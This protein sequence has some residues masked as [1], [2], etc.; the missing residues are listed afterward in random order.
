MEIPVIIIKLVTPFAV[1]G[2]FNKSRVKYGESFLK[3]RSATQ[4]SA[5]ERPVTEGG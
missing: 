4:C 2:V 1:I 3:Y 5:F